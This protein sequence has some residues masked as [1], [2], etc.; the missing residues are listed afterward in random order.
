MARNKAYNILWVGQLRSFDL[1]VFRLLR[2]MNRSFSILHRVASLPPERRLRGLVVLALALCF[3]G[4][5]SDNMA[6]KSPED[7]SEYPGWT[8]AASTPFTFMSHQ[9]SF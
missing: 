4:C 7:G 5:A 6:T 8:K 3:A 1:T 2:S 9:Q